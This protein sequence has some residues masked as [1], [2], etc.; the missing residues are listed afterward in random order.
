VWPKA[1]ENFAIKDEVEASWLVG[2]QCNWVWSIPS[3]A[4][5]PP[6]RQAALTRPDLSSLVIG[7]RFSIHAIYHWHLFVLGSYLSLDAALSATLRS[8]PC[9]IMMRFASSLEIPCFFAK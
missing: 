4:A 7:T 2:A 3:N 8:G 1:W 9:R 6:A 5:G